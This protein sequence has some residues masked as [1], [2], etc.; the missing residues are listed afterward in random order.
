MKIT[1]LLRRAGTVVGLAAVMPALLV[2]MASPVSANDHRCNGWLLGAIDGNVTITGNCK[3]MAAT[4]SGNVM[5]EDEDQEFTIT[6]V[7]SMVLGNIENKGY[8]AV[9]VGED[10]WVKGNINNYGDGAV[11]IK[12]MATING[13]ISNT[14]FGALSVVHSTVEGNIN[15]YGD[16]DLTVVHSTVEG[17]IESEGGSCSVIDT[18]DKD[19][20]PKACDT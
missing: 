3:I 11:T 7:N 17:I 14:G 5:Q 20:N 16:G 12:D 15:N 6:V 9:T 4:I 1:Q 10:A 2:L 8:G 18:L 13:N 19:G